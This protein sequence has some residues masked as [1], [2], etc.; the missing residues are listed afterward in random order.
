MEISK[1]LDSEALTQ[2]FSFSD[3]KQRAFYGLRGILSGIVAD[4]KLNEKELLFLDAWLQSQQS[5]SDD[6][7]VLRI[8]T[9]VGEVLADGHISPAELVQMQTLIEAFVREQD[10]EVNSKAQVNELLGF[11]SGVASDGVLNDREVEGLSSWLDQH[12]DVRTAWPACVLIDRLDVIL[13]DGFISEEEREDL[14][15][16]LQR[17]T[18]TDAGASGV[19]YEASTEVWEDQVD[20]VD[21]EG[22]T[23]CL[24][25]DFVSGDRNHVDTMLR[26]KGADLS[27]NVNKQV[28]YLVIGTLASRDWLY[29]SH[30]RKIEK[31]LLLK[32]EGCTIQII[33]ERTLLKFLG[34]VNRF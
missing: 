16:T 18:A 23:F 3:L 24:T 13:E 9:R 26:L 5:L 15:Q 4:Q 12:Q 27:P 32:R 10:D 20:S 22:R 30:G 34:A 21:I 1:Q 28:D 7:E 31:A 14:L 8:L 6:E 19:R 11:L 29:T 25:G 33:T 17:I 2:A